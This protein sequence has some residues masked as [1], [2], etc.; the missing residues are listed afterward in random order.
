MSLTSEYI[1]R[2]LVQ[3]DGNPA[4]QFG[5]D[6]E[7]DSGLFVG[8]WTSTIDMRGATSE[9]DIELDYYLGYHYE[10]RTQLA[11]TL[12]VLRYTYP[13]QI[14]SHS[15]DY[16]EVLLMATWR[17]RYSIEFGYTNNYYG[18]DSIARHWE[19]RSDWPV[20]NVWVISAALGRND[21]SSIGVSRYLHWDVGASARFSRVVLDLRW[22][23]NEPL[24]GYAASLAAG[25][26]LV[27]SISTAF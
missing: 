20:A 18:L 27:V 1:Y 15:Y 13:G 22:Y 9:R 14:G 11:A 21:L 17:E 16:H 24:G 6:Y 12:T 5:L 2:G 7:F 19:L 8:A 26:Q 3:S 10:S 23:D 4:F 25:P